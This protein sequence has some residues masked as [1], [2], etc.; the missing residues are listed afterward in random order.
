[1]TGEEICRIIN[2][3]IDECGKPPQFE[4]GKYDYLSYFENSH[5]EQSLFLYDSEDDVVIVYIG[6]AGWE[7]PQIL[8][9]EY[10][11][12]NKFPSDEIDEGILPDSSE[13]NWLV[14]C[15]T[16]VRPIIETSRE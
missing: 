16:A 7:N 15:K 11:L 14:A 12:K 13:E 1:M 8:P 3:H 10:I 6:D 9:S 4:F 2:Q 5:R